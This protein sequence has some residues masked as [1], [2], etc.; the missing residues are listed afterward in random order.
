MPA[1]V[2]A[3]TMRFRAVRPSLAAAAPMTGNP[4]QSMKVPKTPPST[5]CAVA[6]SIQPTLKAR[7]SASLISPDAI[8]NSQCAPPVTLPLIFTL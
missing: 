2:L 6:G 4:R 5:S 8:A 7:N 3:Q 1:L